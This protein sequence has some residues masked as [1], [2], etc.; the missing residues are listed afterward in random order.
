MQ[1]VLG[2]AAHASGPRKQFWLH[3]SYGSFC[4]PFHDEVGESLGRHISPSSSLTELSS[5]QSPNPPLPQRHTTHVQSPSPYV[6]KTSVLSLRFLQARCGLPFTII[7][8]NHNQYIYYSKEIAVWIC[9]SY[10]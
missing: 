1:R 3:N 9:G 7:N 5:P 10:F 2:W 6:T 8:Y 4:Q